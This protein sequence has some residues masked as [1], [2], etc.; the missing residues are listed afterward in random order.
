MYI[1]EKQTVLYEFNTALEDLAS[2]VII[3][4]GDL[5]PK[6]SQKVM[7]LNMKLEEFRRNN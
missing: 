1:K 3:N 5:D 4:N 6:K 7:E 2:G